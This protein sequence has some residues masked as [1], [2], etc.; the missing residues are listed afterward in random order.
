V[1]GCGRAGTSRAGTSLL[2]DPAASAGP[3]LLDRR[4]CFVLGKGGVGKST[5]ACALGVLAARSG[6][7]TLLIEVAGQHGVSTLFRSAEVSSNRETELAPNLFGTSIDPEKTTEE[8]LAEQ[9]H[10]RPLVELMTR[11]RAF[12]AFAAAAPGLAEVVTVGKVWRLATAISADS[13]SPVWDFLVVDCPATGHGVAL[14]E[15]A[16][17]V[18]EMA[19]GGP[20]RDQASRIQEV[21]NHPA[22][23]GVAVVARPEELAV[24]EAAETIERLR[25]DGLP[26]AL[27]VMNAISV[28]RF[29]DDDAR[30][31]RAALAEAG[32]ADRDP[33]AAAIAAALEHWERQEAEDELA[34]R[35][36]SEVTV[37]IVELPRIPRRRMDLRAVEALADAMA[38]A[39]EPALC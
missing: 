19:G 25:G 35:L 6:R 2:P 16:G 21:V 20:I 32:P 39:R 33:R 17:N 24:A 5:V 34:D 22:A 13:G 7:R 37:P 36:R 23:T 14:L 29:D 31:L 11:S 38:G 1:A 18:A 10:V 12:H 26:V 3:A 9:L 28:H 8:Y 4:L 30:A 15:T 27:C